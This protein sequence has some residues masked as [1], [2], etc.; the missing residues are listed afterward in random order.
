MNDM[1]NGANNVA[2][3]CS[4]VVVGER[5]R[6][7]RREKREE[8]REKENEQYTQHPSVPLPFPSFYVCVDHKKK[9]GNNPQKRSNSIAFLLLSFP[10]LPQ[11]NQPVSQ[12]MV[13]RKL[14][15]CYLFVCLFV[16]CLF[17]IYLFVCYL[18]VCLS[19]LSCLSCFLARS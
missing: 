6:E 8:R 10:F 18:F 14:L 9:R 1:A 13:E 19:C 2:V 3:S 11:K 17:V 7:E 12:R 15:L 4:F 16:I 5:Q